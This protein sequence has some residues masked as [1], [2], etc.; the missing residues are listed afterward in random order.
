[1]IYT[2]MPRTPVMIKDVIATN[3]I[4][5]G[6]RMAERTKSTGSRV[7]MVFDVYGFLG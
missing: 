3:C 5:M 7:R 1:M 4:T 2:A 6:K